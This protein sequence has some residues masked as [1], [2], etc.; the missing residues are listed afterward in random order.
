MKDNMKFWKTLNPLFLEKSH[1]K[2]SISPINKEGLI[3][4]NED[5]AKTFN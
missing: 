4:E 2:E 5:L 3:T 1:S